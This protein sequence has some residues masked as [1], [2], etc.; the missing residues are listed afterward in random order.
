VHLIDEYALANYSE[1]YLIGHGARLEAKAGAVWL[2]V[3]EAYLR[4]S[5]TA[6]LLS[7]YG[8]KGGTVRLGACQTGL[9]NPLG[10]T[11][12]AELNKGLKTLKLPSTVYAPKGNYGLLSNSPLPIVFIV[13]NEGLAVGVRRFNYGDGFLKINP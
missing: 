10:R 4:G 7:D 12:A 9:K 11:F 2:K 3:D 8:F 1:V 5:E 13:D 6:K